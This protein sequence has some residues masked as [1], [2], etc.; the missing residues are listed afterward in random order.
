MMAQQMTGDTPRAA[1][2]RTRTGQ[3][4]GSIGLVLLIAVVLVGAG[5]GLLLI[6]RTRA[7]PF[8]LGLLAVLAMACAPP[9]ATPRAR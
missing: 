1:V 7:E 2:D 5:V 3:H 9:A 4:G 6:G 8:I